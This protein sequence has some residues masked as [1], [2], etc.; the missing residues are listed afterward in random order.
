MSLTGYNIM[1]HLPPLS[2]YEGV[3]DIGQR[4]SIK[5]LILG[6]NSVTVLYCLY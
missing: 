3:K 5:N 1:W 2:K 6:V 4:M